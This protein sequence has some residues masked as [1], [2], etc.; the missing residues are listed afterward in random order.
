MCANVVDALAN[1]KILYNVA[2]LVA[3]G[4]TE[5]SFTL[6]FHL[7]DVDIAYFN[8]L[9]YWRRQ[10]NLDESV[11]FEAFGNEADKLFHA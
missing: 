10:G 8:V 5:F 11:R 4:E 9:A 1:C 7:L 2:L 3:I 6:Y